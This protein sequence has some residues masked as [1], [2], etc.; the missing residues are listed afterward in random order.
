[1]RSKTQQKID[2]LHAEIKALV[3]AEKAHHDAQA[4]NGNDVL[5]HIAHNRIELAGQSPDIR[6]ATRIETLRMP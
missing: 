1:M 4:P 5:R 2:A 6:S 3:A